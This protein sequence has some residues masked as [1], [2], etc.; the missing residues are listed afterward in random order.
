MTAKIIIDRQGKNPCDISWC[1]SWIRPNP[2][3]FNS[4]VAAS[5]FLTRLQAPQICIAADVTECSWR[6]ARPRHKSNNARYS[7]VPRQ[8][9]LVNNMVGVHSTQWTSKLRPQEIGSPCCFGGSWGNAQTLKISIK[10]EG[11][12]SQSNKLF[13]LHKIFPTR[14]SKV[15]STKSTIL[16]FSWKPHKSH[17]QTKNKAKK[18]GGK[19][20][21]WGTAQTKLQ[22]LGLFSVSTSLWRQ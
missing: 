9:I 20:Q 13:V 5:L 6:H 10:F 3:F 19:K 12:R 18:K 1:C 11:H 17:Y 15:L 2:T 16:S 14:S 7:S 8:W 22:K 21:K 4:M